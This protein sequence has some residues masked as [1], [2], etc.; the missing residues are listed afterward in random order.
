MI[1][2]SLHFGTRVGLISKSAGITSLGESFCWRKAKEI[3][4]NFLFVVGYAEEGE[5]AWILNYAMNLSGGDY[6][7]SDDF[8]ILEFPDLTEE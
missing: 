6:F 3:G 5:G 4:Q 8:E 2:K 1:A 7:Q